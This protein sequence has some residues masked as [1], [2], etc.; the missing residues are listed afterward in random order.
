MTQRIAVYNRSTAPLGFDLAA[1]VAALNEYVAT[2]VQP[3]WNVS[4]SL[5]VASGPMPGEW[6]MV[7]LDDA[8]APGA[9][10]YHDEETGQPLAKVF[11][12]TVRQAN[13]SLTV[14][15]SHELVEMLADPLC[16]C[17]AT[18][19]DPQT[20]FAL[21]P[22][23]PVEADSLGF[24]IGGFLMSNFV[25]PAWFDQTQA[26]RPGV[27]FDHRGVISRPFELHSGGYAI[28]LK[29]GAYGQF[30]GSTAKADAF[31]REDRRGHRSEFRAARAAGT[32]DVYL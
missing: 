17:Y 25:Y 32:P 1:F 16:V 30:F 13:V 9:L 24:E 21:E 20:L 15:A 7:F 3:S 14:S 2:A 26:G 19:N 6:G 28:T 23:D 11:V 12:R 22:A 18:S 4:A 8:D 27:K 29:G 5:H 10:A 31:A